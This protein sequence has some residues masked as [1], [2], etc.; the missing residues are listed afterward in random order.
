MR[1]LVDCRHFHSLL[2][3]N[4][5]LTSAGKCAAISNYEIKRSQTDVVMEIKKKYQS[6][7]DQCQ[8][9]LPSGAEEL[10][11]EAVDCLVRQGQHTK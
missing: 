3:G 1:K 8:E 2:R 10:A 11:R 7:A 4:N 6:V 5:S 9:I